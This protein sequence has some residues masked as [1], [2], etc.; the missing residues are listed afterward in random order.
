MTETKNNECGPLTKVLLCGPSGSGKTT[1][2]NFFKEYVEKN[3]PEYKIAIIDGDVMRDTINA[4]LKFTTLD[5]L[6][7]VRR[8]DALAE[9]LYKTLGYNLVVVPIIA[10]TESSRHYL[11]LMKFKNIFI[12]RDS[13]KKEDYKGL[14]AKNKAVTFE[15]ENEIHDS[16]LIDRIII[17]NTCTDND[18][19]H[20]IEC[21]NKILKTIKN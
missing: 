16:P 15:G 1:I 20:L 8:I 5:I 4:D 3:F 6:E 9:F 14:Y 21:S 12:S 17:N 19:S 7:N 11:K 10:A 13:Y 18:T 2:A